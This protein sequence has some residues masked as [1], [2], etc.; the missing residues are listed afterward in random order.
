MLSHPTFT[1]FPESHWTLFHQLDSAITQLRR[2]NANPA[3][4]PTTQEPVEFFNAYIDFGIS[5]YAAKLLQLFESVELS[6]ET[7]KNL[8][9]AQSGRAIIENVATLRYYSMHTEIVKASDAWKK[10]ALTD[11]VLRKATETLDR[12]LR[13]SRF[14]WDAFTEGKFD[15]LTK[16]PDQPHLAQVN[17]ITCLQKW[18]KESP[19]LE[20][21]YDLFCDLVHPNIGSNLLVLG[22][23]EG[24]LVPGAQ[25]AEDTATFIIA[26]SLAGLLGAF[27][28][29]K[30]SIAGL[31][32]LRF[33]PDV[34]PPSR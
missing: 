26:P 20:S 4:F 15:E 22:V 3:P 18:F 17:S 1:R 14:S 10:R 16:T 6:I 19:K 21:L 34:P 13:G 23:R 11:P 29:A 28:T 33:Y 12:F 5:T 24:K 25:V 31:A 2:F 27:N 30:E 7:K 32:G 8:I 9:Y